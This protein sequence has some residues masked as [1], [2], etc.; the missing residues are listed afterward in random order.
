MNLNRW[1]SLYRKIEDDFEFSRVREI[2]AR[3]LLSSMLGDDIVKIDELK[4]AVG[5]E[6]Y[7]IGNSPQLERDIEN[8]KETYPIIA[9]D[10]SVEILMNYGIKP[11]IVL[12]DLDGNLEAILDSGAIVGVHAHG[13]N[14]SKLKYSTMFDKKFGTTQIEPLWNIYN[15]GGF[16]DGDRCVFLAV[17]FGAIVHLIGFD[18]SKPRYKYGKS[19]ERKSKKLKWAKFLIDELRKEGAVIIDESLNSE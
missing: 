11:K 10:D 6:V 19:M 9:A 2:R 17:H 8:M 13:D 4:R 12:T 18:F 14:T 7:V 5:K 16:T 3:N 15:F 1:M